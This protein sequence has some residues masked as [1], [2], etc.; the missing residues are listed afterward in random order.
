MLERC[1]QAEDDFWTPK[2]F[3]APPAP[4]VSGEESRL[5]R[6]FGP[7]VVQ[8]SLTDNGFWASCD[9]LELELDARLR[10]AKD[11]LQ[12]TNTTAACGTP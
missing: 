4:A 8:R 2:S 9:E 6:S 7:A 3:A 10:T 1:Q 11:V 5:R 12:C